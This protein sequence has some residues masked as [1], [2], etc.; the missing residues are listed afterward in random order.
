MMFG[1]DIGTTYGVVVIGVVA[2]AMYANH[3]QEL[4]RHS[5]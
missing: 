5:T 2:G 4:I 3:A 1:F